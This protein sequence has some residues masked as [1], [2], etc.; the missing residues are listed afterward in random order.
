M[1]VVL[2]YTHDIAAHALVR[3][4]QSSGE[5]A[6]LLT[7]ADLSRQGWR[8]VAGTRGGGQACIDGRVIDAREI[9]AVITR[10]PAVSEAELG[11][12]H[13]EDRQYAAAEMQAFLLAWLTSLDCPVLNRP[14]PSNLG[15]PG[16]SA[17]QWV[18]RAPRLGLQARP[19]SQRAVFVPDA[20]SVANQRVQADSIFV[21]V[22]GDRAFVAGGGAPGDSDAALA[23]AARVLSRDAGM[24]LLR[25]YFERE[26]K[27][28]PIFLEA[29]LWI[30]VT[31]DTVALA[32]LTRCRELALTPPPCA[33]ASAGA[34]A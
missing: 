11:H 30:D 27:R 9:S 32:L 29:G 19:F 21:D 34:T 5:N 4:W 17:A 1:I 24:E 23:D 28:E 13:E 22:V 3:R 33:A 18:Q 8:Y 2:A 25:V 31:A 7:C 10:M 20:P 16:W 15:G 14:S 6:A 26:P 12:L